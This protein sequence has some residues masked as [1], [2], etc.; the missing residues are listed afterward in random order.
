[1]REHRRQLDSGVEESEPH[2]FAVRK[3]RSRQARAPRPPHPV[4]NVRDGRET[5]LSSGWDG[6][7]DKAVSTHSRNEI[8]LQ[9]RLDTG[10]IRSKDFANSRFGA[11]D[12]AN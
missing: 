10:Q 2:D 5:P 12:V 6:R 3:A 7:I 9:K 11:T 4:P 8:F 1:M